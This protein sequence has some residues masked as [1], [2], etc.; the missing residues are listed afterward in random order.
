[1]GKLFKTLDKNND[2]VLTV[3]EISSGLKELEF[4]TA[5]ELEQVIKS[6]DTDGSGTI[7][8]T[9]F[10]AA[11]MDKAIYMKQEK[12]FMAFKA[13]DLDGSGKISKD[14]LKK[15]LGSEEQFKNKDDKYWDN[16]IREADKNGDGEID[17]NEF[18][19]MM[20]KGFMG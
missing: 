13:L 3:D 11:S 2:G 4:H 9:E 8:Y 12:L 14:E 10:I 7:D 20:G 15:V 17:Y 19:E 6:M 18:S 5:K 16:M 1:M